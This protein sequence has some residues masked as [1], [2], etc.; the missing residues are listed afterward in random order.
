[1]LP[2]AAE[3]SKQ[4]LES[5]LKDHPGAR[6]LPQDPI[7]TGPFF[8]HFVQTPSLLLAI[9]EIAPNVR[10]V[11]LDG[12]SHPKDVNPTWMG[13]SVGKWEGDT[14]VVDTTGFNDRSWIGLSPH[15]EMLHIVE[16]Y[17]RPDL[18]HLEIAITVEDPGAFAKP[19]NINMT[20]NLAPGEDVL[21]S[22]CENNKLEHLVGK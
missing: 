11:F 4:M 17:R 19:W 10:Q 12:R 3:R 8:F 18:G 22:V 20:W 1:M 16:R 13:H 15:T 7:L 2:W 5:N 14:L 6:C 9:F 21:E